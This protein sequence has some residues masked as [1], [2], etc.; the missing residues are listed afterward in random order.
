MIELILATDMMYHAKTL[1]LV[2]NKILNFNV[3]AGKNIEKM[4]SVTSNTLFDE[5]QEILN[6]LIHTCDIGHSAKM[7]DLSYKWTN[8]IMEEFWNQGDLEK[9]L[10]VPVSFL[11]D[12]N[13]AEVPR[14]QVVFIKSILCPNFDV[15]IELFPS[16]IHFKANLENNVSSWIN[17]LENEKEEKEKQKYY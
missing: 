14:N 3:S 9:K 4:L 10:G 12:R 5:Q 16:L 1:S 11:C 15:L 7:F 13:T 2:K 17:I 6:F 8:C